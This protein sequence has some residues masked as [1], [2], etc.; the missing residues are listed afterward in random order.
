MPTYDYRCTACGEH[1]RATHSMSAEKPACPACSG[2]LEQ[3]FLTAPAIAGAS[4][5]AGD[6]GDFG[7]C[8]MPGGGCATGTC[9]FQS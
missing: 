6:F 8:S 7:S 5:G 3:V 1:H 4:S 2:T 9:P